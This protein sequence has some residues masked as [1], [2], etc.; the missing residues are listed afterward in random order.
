MWNEITCHIWH[1]SKNKCKK[2]LRKL[3][4]D[5]LNSEYDYI[6]TPTLIKRVKLAKNV[7]KKFLH[8]SFFFLQIIS[9]ILSSLSCY[10]VFIHITIF[11]SSICNLKLSLVSLS[12]NFIFCTHCPATNSLASCGKCFCNII[13][14]QGSY[15]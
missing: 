5:I 4:F 1:L 6:D 10:L 3:L 11:I 2:T 12:L 13:C 14:L 7:E 9:L 8:T 15:E